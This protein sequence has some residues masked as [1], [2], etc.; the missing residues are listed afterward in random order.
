VCAA[1]LAAAG[2]VPLPEP[3]SLVKWQ[4]GRAVAL[5]G[6][7]DAPVL[8]V[9]GEENG[10]RK[11]DVKRAVSGARRMEVLDVT[12]GT[13]GTVYALVLASIPMG[14]DRRLL[15]RFAGENGGA[16]DDL[17]ERRCRLLAATV[18]DTVWCFGEGPAGML[19][20]RLTGPPGS[21]RFWLPAE[22]PLRG[23]GGARFA[24]M[25][26][27]APGRAL[28]ILPETELLAEV[29]LHS[30]LTR[31]SRLPAIGGIAGSVSFA[32]DGERLLALL[33]VEG[34]AGAGRLNARFGLF[35]WRGAWIRL[36][37]GRQWLRGARLA[38][39]EQGKAWIWDRA[40]RRLESVSLPP[41]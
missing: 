24:W 32:A 12:A 13:D 37:P 14:Q 36:E 29:D 28:V 3:V 26:A 6:A 22:G 23:A 2:I 34:A 8:L 41:R 5:A 11:I 33:P 30:G 17:G 19:L 9:A 18:P 27:A 1:W 10:T 39:A 7:A 20:H 38:G 25:G 15:C 21:P 31:L 4:H 16:C 40:A 35:E